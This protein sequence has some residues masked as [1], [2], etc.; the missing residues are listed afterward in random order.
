MDGGKAKAT[1]VTPVLETV[2]APTPTLMEIPS[3]LVRVAGTGDKPVDPINSWPF[4]S[5]GA[6][7]IAPLVEIMMRL[8]TS[9]VPLL[10]P[11][12]AMGSTP[13]VIIA[14][15]KEGMSAATKARN[16]GV[17]AIPLAGPAK[18]VFAVSV[19]KL[20]A[21]VPPAAVNGDPATLRKDG[22]VNA[23]LMAFD[24]AIVPVPS[25]TVI[26]ALPAVIVPTAGVEPVDPMSN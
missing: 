13:V 17:A 18:M 21:M 1:F 9:A 24:T 7:T 8:L 22:T 19:A 15:S 5:A 16:V 25:A 2:I 4:V 10:V 26:P 23:T 12:R 14:A 3:P 20:I 11:P 6:S